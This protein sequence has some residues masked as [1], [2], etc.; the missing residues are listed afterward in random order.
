MKGSEV[1]SISA[2]NRGFCL[3]HVLETINQS[4]SGDHYARGRDGA[5]WNPDAAMSQ[6]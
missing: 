1:I 3:Y 2:I 6:E 5:W 4:P